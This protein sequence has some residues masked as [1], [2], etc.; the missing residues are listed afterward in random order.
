L[1]KPIERLGEQADVVRMLGVDEAR[2][3]L[4]VYRLL[5]VA[6]QEGVLDV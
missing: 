5:K 6:V 4:T 2:G 1:T 3:L